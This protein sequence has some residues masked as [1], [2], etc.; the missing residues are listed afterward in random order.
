MSSKGLARLDE[1]I[2]NLAK[3]YAPQVRVNRS[4][5]PGDQESNGAESPPYESEDETEEEEEEEEEEET[6]SDIDSED[7]DE[8]YYS[9]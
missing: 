5:A 1:C 7:D 2:T 8:F 6:E 4:A 3:Q 9:E